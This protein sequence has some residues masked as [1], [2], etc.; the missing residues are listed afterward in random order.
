MDA[1]NILPNVPKIRH[2]TPN[3]DWKFRDHAKNNMAA[4]DMRRVFGD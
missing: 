2:E 4:D 1:L 3:P